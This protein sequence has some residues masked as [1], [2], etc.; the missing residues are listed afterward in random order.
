MESS[1]TAT[2]TAGE[3]GFDAVFDHDAAKVDNERDLERN[4]VDAL[5]HSNEEYFL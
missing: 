1:A 5:L 4:G 2:L 3:D